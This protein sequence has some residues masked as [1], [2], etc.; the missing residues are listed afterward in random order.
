[1]KN[2]NIVIV[3][4]F[5]F[6]F[7]GHS[8]T[9][10]A[11]KGLKDF[12]NYA[13]I[14]SIKIYERLVKKGY[15]DS[16]MLKK[17]G[18]ANYFNANYQEASKW[19]E[20]LISLD[21]NVEP[22]YL[23]R[24]S[25][26]L[27]STGDYKKA[28]KYL[29]EFSS[30]SKADLRAQLYSSNQ[31]YLSNIAKRK[32]FF[33]AENAAVNSIYSDYGGSIVNQEFVF[34]TTRDT[35]S[36]AKRKHAWTNQYFSNLYSSKIQEDYSLSNASRFSRIINSKFHESSAVFTKD[37]KTVYFTRNNY[38]N[39]KKGKNA[40]DVVLLKVYMSKL[41]NNGKWT[42]PIELPFNSN[43]Y[44][45]AHPTLSKDEKTMYFASDMPGTLGASDI[46]KV[47]ILEDGKYGTPENLGNKINTE[48]RETFPYISNEDEL[49]FASD[50]HLGL[51]GLDILGVKILGNGSYS[52][53]VNLAEPINSSQ[54]D[55]GF[56]R[57]EGT[58]NGFFTSN[59]EGGKGNDDIYS[60]KQLKNLPFETNKEIKVDV[61]EEDTNNRIAGAKVE[62]FDENMNKLEEAFL[63]PDGTVDFKKLKPTTNYF[64]R[65]SKEGYDSQEKMI[66][67]DNSAKPME[68]VFKMKK[69]EQLFTVGSDLAKTFKISN[70]YFDLN[71]W[72][73][74]DKAA[75][76]LA[77]VVEVMKDNPNIK[78]S[79]RSH[80]DCR[81]THKYNQLLSERRAKSAMEWII[82]NGIASDRLMSKGYGE[83][84]LINKCKDGVDC[85]EA[86][87]Q[88]NR[89]IEFIVIEN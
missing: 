72:N 44:S 87:H 53:V 20:Q 58:K 74:N 19:Y 42:E 3:I 89:R 38:N 60:F 26:S 8:Q 7:F 13:Y 65:V 62:L 67:T 29:A 41:S 11:K 50:G 23:M 45:V 56:V 22:E 52:P 81:Q 25:I 49:F 46:F 59:R 24:Y 78:V 10:A 33:S 21:A 36:V 55:F 18:D 27:K 43:E 70:I 66:T 86:E 63:K 35:G 15:V 54:D 14:N 57:I 48:A 85:T 30:K 88:E 16:D 31:D 17:L 12:E 83:T 76:D 61:L 64:V 80:T 69:T 5:L 77:K 73:I 1:M 47:S 71:K 84:Q 79:I 37:G 40:K 75:I 68:F 34:T 32:D 6:S 82:K 28:N 4:F 39:G 9:S 51:G 2:N